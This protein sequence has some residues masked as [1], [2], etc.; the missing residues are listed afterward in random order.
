MEVVLLVL[1]LVLSAEGYTIAQQTQLHSDLASGYDRRVRPGQNRTLP[2]VIKFNFYFASLKEFSEAESKIGI[3]GSLGLEWIDSRLSWNP[4]TYGGDLYVTTLF[5]SDIWVPFL[6]L[7]NP[8]AKLKKV[9]LDEMSCTVTDGGYVNCLPPNLYEATCDADVTYYPFDSQTC[10]LKF[11]VPGYS[12]SD[13][14]LRPALPTFRMDLYEENGL[15]SITSTRIYYQ[16]NVFGFEELRLEINMKRRTTYYIAGLILPI[17]LMN[18]IQILVFILP[19]ESGERMGF[20]ITVLLAVA[21]FLTIIQ[22]K[23]PEASEPSVA[24]LTYKLLVDMLLGCSMVIAVVIGLHFYH[25]TEDMEISTRLKNFA[26]SMNFCC[27]RRKTKV[28]VCDDTEKPPVECVNDT[29][30]I[31][32]TWN[33]VGLAFDKLFFIVFFVSLISNNIVYLTTMAA[34][35]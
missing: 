8:F 32:V 4:S 22:D 6:V 16:V 33:D 23:L 25:K 12:M 21:V 3:V 2:I 19:M 30:D 13:I 14:L 27:K 29:C 18:F 7:M 11:Y 20:S 15:W 17:C 9:L 28:M 5:T 26:R 24:N 35:S 31:D 34:I 10:T 1:C